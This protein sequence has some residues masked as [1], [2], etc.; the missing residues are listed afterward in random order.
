M[1]TSVKK[2]HLVMN[3]AKT[4]LKVVKHV[5]PRLHSDIQKT[6]HS[7]APCNIQGD[8]QKSGKTTNAGEYWAVP[9]QYAVERSGNE[10]PR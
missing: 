3:M 9:E 2:L 7:G 4:K 6:C 5:E 1:I 8:S 10:V